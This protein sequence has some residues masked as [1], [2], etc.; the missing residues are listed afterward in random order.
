MTPNVRA[1][2][3]AAVAL[4]APG[5]GAAQAFYWTGQAGLDY[6]RLDTERAGGGTSSY[7]RLDVNLKLDAGGA[8]P[9][10]FSWS[11]GVGYRRLSASRDGVDDVRDQLSYRLRTSVLTDPRSPVSADLH[12]AR[13]NEST[14]LEGIS[15]TRF[16][17][18]SYGGE[19]RLSP[20]DRPY[21]V[22]AYEFNGTDYD[23]PALGAVDRTVHSLSATTGLGGTSYTYR[24]SYRLNRSEGTFP[25]DRYDDH[26]VDVLADARVAENVKL[27]LGESYY[28]RSPQETTLAQRQELNAFTANLRSADGRSDVHSVTYGY[29][30]GVQTSLVSPDLERTHHQLAYAMERRF[31]SPEWRIRGRV[32]VSYADDRVGGV[33]T[34]TGGESLGLLTYWRRDQGPGDRVEVHAGPTVALLHPADSDTRLGWGA[35]A[36]GVLNRPVGAVQTS[37]SYDLSY[38]TDV[39]AQAGWRFSQSALG[40][41][42]GRLGLGTLRGSL[43][44]S[45]QRRESPLLGGA[46]SRSVLLT[47][48]YGWSRHELS[49]QGAI[50]D[51]AEGTVSGVQDG[52]FLAPGFSSR[53]RMLTFA[54]ST[55]PWSFL[56]LRARLRYLLT[57][58][59]DRPSTDEKEAYAAVEYVY[60]SLRFAIEDRYVIAGGLGGET[61]Y[62]QVFVR[63]YRAFGS[64]F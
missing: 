14:S 47:T 20:R 21:L 36:G 62:N 19:L 12:A 35:T 2:A 54:A 4:L 5:A 61:R 59:P 41:A 24:G 37:A 25:L 9:G 11:A 30:H 28:L 1:L 31:P 27:T 3:A 55:S 43:N 40:S 8:S 16:H 44:L 38:A 13:S 15:S 50:Q 52:L 64:R 39:D 48:A 57:D 10:L 42:T 45:A 58:L 46:A 29:T 7:P 22:A 51:G 60:A 17:N 34:R 53:H 18:T 49:L 56:A 26:R 23:T 63:A 32:R 33:P 6:Q